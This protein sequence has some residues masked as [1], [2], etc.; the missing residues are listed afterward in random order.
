VYASI[1]FRA[2]VCLP[3]FRGVLA[4]PFSSIRCTFIRV[5]CLP[6]EFRRLLLM[7]QPTP[8]IFINGRELLYDSI[9]PKG[10]SAACARLYLRRNPTERSNDTLYKERE[11]ALTFFPEPGK[12]KGIG[13]RAVVDFEA[14]AHVGFMDGIVTRVPPSTLGEAFTIQ[15]SESPDVFVNSVSGGSLATFINEDL[16]DPNCSFSLA[17]YGGKLRIRVVTA[18]RIEAGAALSL[19][20]RGD[21]VSGVVS[22]EGANHSWG[23]SVTPNGT[24]STNTRVCANLRYHASTSAP[25]TSML[26]VECTEYYG[27]CAVSLCCEA[28]FKSHVADWA[29][30]DPADRSYCAP[31]RTYRAAPLVTKRVTPRVSARR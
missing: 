5:R 18:R 14:G 26:C 29:T 25:L 6:C 16:T 27:G 3:R 23:K 12:G 1:S 30:G 15:L 4:P 8:P 24:F 19:N 21:V 10:L 31:R 17:V 13:V 11:R 28:C 9:D 22:R 7:A 20:Y 2:L